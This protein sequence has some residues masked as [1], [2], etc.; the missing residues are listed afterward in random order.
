MTDRQ[1]MNLETKLQRSL[2]GLCAVAFGVLASFVACPSV[3]AGS[4]FMK[5]GY[6]IQGAVVERSDL[7][8]VVGWDNGKLTIYRRFVESSLYDIGDEERRAEWDRQRAEEARAE[9]E[10]LAGVGPVRTTKTLPDSLVDFIEAQGGGEGIAAF[11]SGSIPSVDAPLGG[12]PNATNLFAEDGGD[13]DPFGGSEAGTDGDPLFPDGG[14]T[15]TTQTD[16]AVVSKEVLGER[17]DGPGNSF[18]I[19]PPLGWK[20][21]ETAEYVEIA[22]DGTDA[23]RPSVNV[24]AFDRRG[25]EWNECVALAAEVRTQSLD[26]FVVRSE[27]TRALGSGREAFEVVGTATQDNKTLV[28]RQVLFAQAEQIWLFSGFSVAD[29][30]NFRAIDESFASVEFPEIINE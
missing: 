8:I 7:S 25:L 2:F 5:N 6:I 12:D 28:V 13:E 20:V 19:R 4:V 27:G 14:N 22:P 9:A 16:V 21:R 24:L 26:E 10:A 23:D 15:D 29:D 1:D 3:D 11:G 17:V 30:D 18:S